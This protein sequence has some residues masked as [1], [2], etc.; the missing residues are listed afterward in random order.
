MRWLLVFVVWP[1]VGQ[2]LTMEEA[3][4]RALVTSPEVA[5]VRAALAVTAFQ[6]QGARALPVPEFRLIVNNVALDPEA[7]EQRNSVA[8]R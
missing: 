6:M 2:V 1:V 5:A 7:A 3:V 8:I 4:A